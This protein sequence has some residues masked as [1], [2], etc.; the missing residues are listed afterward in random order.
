MQAQAGYSCAMPCEPCLD[1]ACCACACVWKRQVQFAALPHFE[2]KYEDFKAD[3]VVLRRRFSSE[4]AGPDGLVRASPDKLPAGAL[5][6]STANIWSVIRSQKD[7]NLPAHKV[8]GWTCIAMAL[9]LGCQGMWWMVCILGISGR[10]VCAED[11]TLPDMVPCPVVSCRTRS[12]LPASAA[13]RS[14][15]TS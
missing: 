12:W 14:R 2:E 6:L 5:A 8:R 15:M 3:S 11:T 13:M 9:C 7:L 10:Q 4:E 1:T